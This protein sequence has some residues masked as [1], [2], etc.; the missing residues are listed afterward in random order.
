VLPGDVID[1]PASGYNRVVKGDRVTLATIA[2]AHGVTAQAILDHARNA[3]LKATRGVVANV[4][5]GDKVIVAY[6]LVPNGVWVIGH[7][8]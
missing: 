7:D 2:A 5:V 6:D 1:I 4:T 8:Q 3:A